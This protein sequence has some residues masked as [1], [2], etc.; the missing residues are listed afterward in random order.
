MI[1]EE[2]TVKIPQT[3]NDS[4]SEKVADVGLAEIM[5]M[6]TKGITPPGIEVYDD[7]PNSSEKIE[8]SKSVIDKKQKVLTC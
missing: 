6:V 4:K 3:T 2:E 8:P 7:M 5:E 1:N